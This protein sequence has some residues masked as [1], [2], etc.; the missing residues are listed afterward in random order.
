MM[1][2]PHTGSAFLTGIVNVQV[3]FSPVSLSV[4]FT[5]IVIGHLPAKCPMPIG[6]HQNDSNGMPR[7]IDQSVMVKLYESAQGAYHSVTN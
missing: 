2:L 5:L 3:M 7:P 6:N 1:L 4:K